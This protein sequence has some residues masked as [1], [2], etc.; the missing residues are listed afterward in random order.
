MYFTTQLPALL[1]QKIYLLIAIQMLFTAV[2]VVSLLPSV[3]TQPSQIWGWISHKERKCKIWTKT[4]PLLCTILYTWY[5]LKFK[6]HDNELMSSSPVS[7]AYDFD[8]TPIVSAI[9]CQQK[10]KLKDMRFACQKCDPYSQSNTKQCTS[11]EPSSPCLHGKTKKIS[12]RHQS[13]PQSI[14]LLEE[15]LLVEKFLGCTIFF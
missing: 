12:Q 7:M 2:G 10:S 13:Q 15:K 14:S 1:L 9:V 3:G 5:G 11:L 6:T 4:L 8:N